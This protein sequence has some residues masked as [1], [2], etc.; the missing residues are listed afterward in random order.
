MDRC[1][2]CAST[3]DK[4]EVLK[5]MV[6]VLRRELQF[7]E[8]LVKGVKNP[9]ELWKESNLYLEVAKFEADTIRTALYFA[10]GNQRKAAD[11]LGIKPSTLNEKIKRYGIV[12]EEF[13][14]APLDFEPEKG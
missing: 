14:N 8:P 3:E 13:L 11:L 5:N 7:L 12:S 9:L 4:L 6:A 1:E 2:R 10:K